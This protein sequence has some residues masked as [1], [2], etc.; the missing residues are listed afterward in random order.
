[1]EKKTGG[2]IA[3]I[4]WSFAEKISVQL[5]SLVVSIILARILSPDDYG[6]LAIVNVFVAIGDALVSGGFGIALVQKKDSNK[7][8][9]DSICILSTLL[10]FA[11]YIMLFFSAP[12]IAEFYGMDHLTP[13]IRVLGIRLI[14]SAVNSV[15]QAYIQ[16]YMQFKKNF[17]VSAIGTVL[18]GVAGIVLALNQ[19]G[20]WALILQNIL[21]VLINTVLLFCVLSWKPSLKYSTKS[22]HSMWGYGGRV[23]LATVVDT[24]K[25]NIRSLVVGKVFSSADL[26]FYNQGKRFPQLLVNDIVNSVGKVLF[27]VFSKNQE[28]IKRNKDLMRFSIKLSSFILLPLIFG[29]VGVADNFVLLFLTEKWMPCI[30]YLQILS[31]VY[32]TRSINTVMKNCLLASGRSDINL[33]HEVITSVIT[34]IMI[35]E[36]AI[37]FR[38]I[39]LIAWSYVIVSLLGTIIFFYFSSKE[40]L[41][42]VKE[43]TRDYMLSFV[44]SVI[45][46][47]VVYFF[48]KIE[49]YLP[50]KFTLQVILG[51]SVYVGLADI[52]KMDELI[53]CK[54]YLSDK[55][56]FRK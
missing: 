13:V 8:D 53:Y 24:L 40:Y 7:Q 48:G 9:F 36:A 18:S 14:V 6:V 3:G 37:R 49:L 45:M 47:L 29:L 21:M 28:D 32:V 34:I 30:P 41:Y 17:I 4:G 25:D 23:F 1:M 12:F 20:V 46:L 33:L 16:K 51:G 5:L 26:A 10:S 43:I 11:F 35:F 27:P 50:V 42:T 56:S 52:L 19:F 22:I 15:Q 39:Q 54:K 55:L 44:L 38:N 2:V 31:L